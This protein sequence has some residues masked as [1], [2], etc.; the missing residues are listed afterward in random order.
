MLILSK[1][2]DVS[3]SK[4]VRI[5]RELQWSNFGQKMERFRGFSSTSWRIQDK[6]RISK[7]EPNFRTGISSLMTVML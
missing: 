5:H 6:R 3:N 4:L 1:L 7:K 2:Y